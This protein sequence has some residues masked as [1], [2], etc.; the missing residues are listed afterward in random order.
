MLEASADIWIQSI[1]LVTVFGF[2]V[3]GLLA[4]RTYTDSMPLPESVVAENGETVYTKAD[5][6]ARQQTFL[7]RGLQQYGS[8]MGHGGYLGPD[9]TAENLRLSASTSRTP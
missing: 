5:I 4:L 2:F 6:T 1:A 3:M 9:H 8:V 7:R